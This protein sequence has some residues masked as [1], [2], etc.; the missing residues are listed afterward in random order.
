M[1]TKSAVLAILLLVAPATV[2]A[3]NWVIQG[4]D[5]FFRVDA[6]TSQGRR[7]PIVSGYIYSN[8]GQMAGN[9]RLIVEGLDSG[10]QVTSTSTAWV[11]GT[12]PPGGRTYFEVPAP[13][14]AASTRV[15]VGS[16]DPVGRGQ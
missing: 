7:G 5:R 6:A 14:D 12:V 11:I 3:Q 1:A 4:A 10:G 2:T 13:R 9:M 16:Y 15:R 8:W